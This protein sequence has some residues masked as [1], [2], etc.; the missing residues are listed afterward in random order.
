MFPLSGIISVF[1]S[2]F[3][4]ENEDEIKTVK[5]ATERKP[6]LILLFIIINPL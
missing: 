2:A 3:T 5:M 4:D 1:V 6:I